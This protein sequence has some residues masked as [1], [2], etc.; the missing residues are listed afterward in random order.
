MERFSD[1][2]RWEK[3]VPLILSLRKQSNDVPR[4]VTGSRCPSRVPSISLEGITPGNERKSKL[5]RRGVK[6]GA[7]GEELAS[8]IRRHRENCDKS[9]WLFFTAPAARN[10]FRF[11][12]LFEYYGAFVL[13][14]GN[15][16]VILCLTLCSL[17]YGFLRNDRVI[18]NLPQSL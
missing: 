9:L 14:K 16:C 17:F 1:F 7:N 3:F 6:F 12:D 11:A 4:P 2:R 10:S 5:K 15:R 8:G 18:S 13:E